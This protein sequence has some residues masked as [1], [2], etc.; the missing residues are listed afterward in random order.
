MERPR[1]HRRIVVLAATALLVAF[2]TASAFAVRDLIVGTPSVWAGSP[3]WSSDGRRIA[4]VV[5]HDGTDDL[6]VMN[7]DGSALRRLR[8]NAAS[9][10]WSPDGRKLAFIG[11][12]GD[13]TRGFPTFDVYVWNASGSALRKLPRTAWSWPL[14]LPDGSVAIAKGKGC[15]PCSGN[16]ELW[17]MN[18]DGSGRRLVASGPF[19]RID[20]SPDGKSIAFEY[21]GRAHFPGIYV[22]AADGS[23]RRWLADGTRPLWSPRGGVIAFRPDRA[24]G[25]RRINADGSGERELTAHFYAI[26]GAQGY[27]WSPDGRKIVFTTVI[28]NNDTEISVMNA[29]GTGQRRLTRH[30]GADEDAAWAPDGRKIAFSRSG[31]IYVMN[32]NGSGQR[33]LSRPEGGN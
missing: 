29:D 27:A 7:A 30:S 14:W 8:R 17:V 3:T 20:W 9:P 12:R 6:Y 21:S 2:G 22:M 15:P 24:D 26:N 5:S 19:G 16:S 23:G 28:G 1:W 10:A 33:R 18:A 31:E 25:L 4:Y 32:A 11:V 13:P